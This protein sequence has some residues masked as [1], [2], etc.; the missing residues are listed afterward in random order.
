MKKAYGHREGARWI[1]TVSMKTH[2][3]RQYK[4]FGFHLHFRNVFSDPTVEG[5]EVRDKDTGRVWYIT[6]ERWLGA[7]QFVRERL[8]YAVPLEAFTL[9]DVG[10]KQTRIERHARKKDRRQKEGNA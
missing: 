8:Q 4:G 9:L 2:Y 1:R 3:W 6:S 10:L 7:A 5:C